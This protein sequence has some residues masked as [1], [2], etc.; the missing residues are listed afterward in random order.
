MVAMSRLKTM[1]RWCWRGRMVWLALLIWGGLTWGVHRF[2][3]VTPVLVFDLAAAN[4]AQDREDDLKHGRFGRRLL[5]GNSEVVAVSA[6]GNVVVHSDGSQQ[7]SR[8]WDVRTGRLQTTL[9]GADHHQA[10]DYF[11]ENPWRQF[12]DSLTKNDPAQAIMQQRKGHVQLV[13]RNTGK[14]SP[15]IWGD[16]V[17]SKNGHLAAY[18]DNNAN[19]L[20]DLETGAIRN[21]FVAPSIEQATLIPI[22]LQCF[23]DDGRLIAGHKNGMV[24][25]IEV[26]SGKII[27]TL[28]A[29]S[30]ETDLLPYDL[31]FSP[32]GAALAWKIGIAVVVS[33]LAG[34]NRLVFPKARFLGWQSSGRVLI[35]IR[36]DG[37]NP[38][39]T[40]TRRLELWKLHDSNFAASWDP[41]PASRFI[42][43]KNGPV[44]LWS[45]PFE[46]I[47]LSPDQRQILFADFV[48]TSKP[49]PWIE[50][51]GRWI[52][53][54][55][56]PGLRMEITILDTEALIPNVELSVPVNDD[57][58]TLLQ[59]SADGRHLVFTDG[60]VV[61]HWPI[62]PR[63]WLKSAAW[64]G[65][66][67]V[68]LVLMYTLWRYWR[69]CKRATIT[70][71]PPVASS[72]EISDAKA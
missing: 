16:Y 28:R 52:Q 60:H 54:P 38:Y 32:D 61:E 18:H 42:T 21:F 31:A 19:H 13:H 8:V 50:E 24:V 45:G 69:G 1:V 43:S 71:I 48:R 3:P 2:W 17:L 23:S 37:P 10:A 27:S 58:S 33:D 51:L 57:R 62:A 34:Q 9:I 59:F 15:P 7:Q 55:A 4:L 68:I 41:P 40:H 46:I 63:S 5:F 49:S 14:K 11:S 20:I 12:I 72:T 67:T 6:D 44:K 35:G 53:L 39:W 36:G 65:G 47:S 25:V 70:P 29:S 56:N 22:K 66:G 30:D 26:A 64:A